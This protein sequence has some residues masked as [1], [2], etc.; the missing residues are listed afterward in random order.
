[1]SKLIS[2]VLAFVF[3]LCAYAAR[4][5]AADMKPEEVVAKHLDGIGSA[6]VRK[7]VKNR[8]VQGNA[9]FKFVVGG[10]GELEGKGGFVSEGN[11]SN[12][13]LKFSGDYRGEQFISDG[14]KTYVGA[15]MSNHKRS[16]LA[17]FIR[18]QDFILKEGLIG[19]ELSTNWALLNSNQGQAK[20][21]YNG[22]KKFDGQQVHDL[23]YRSKKHDDMT[24]HI[25]LDPENFHHIA[26]VYSITLAAGL[27]GPGGPNAFEQTG[28]SG[29]SS[30]QAGGDVTQ[31]AKQ[32]ETRYT[33]EERFADFK[34]GDG[35]TL[36]TKYTL[37]YTQELQSGSTVIYEWDVAADEVSQNV[38]L[39]PRNF[40]VK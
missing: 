40:E 7:S 31:S 11:K 17:E 12:V 30:P 35:I 15:G 18:S 6:D 34:S 37:R 20:L 33:I 32:R 22:L 38:T 24:I 14:N 27:G 4:V 1:M 3:L 25:Y 13:V 8:I 26:T 16:Q 23:R 39:D 21:E 9:K 19:G 5:S 29:P 36:P 10:S 28:L 2:T